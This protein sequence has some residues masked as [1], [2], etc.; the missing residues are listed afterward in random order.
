MSG[1]TWWNEREHRLRR[2]TKDRGLK[3]TMWSAR[4]VENLLVS[5]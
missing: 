5:V 1:C 3:R 2:E 4:E